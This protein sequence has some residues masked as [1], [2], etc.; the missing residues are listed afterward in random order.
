MLPFLYQGGVTMVTF[1]SYDGACALEGKIHESHVR[2][3]CQANAHQ[4]GKN[5]L[6]PENWQLHTPQAMAACVLFRC[7]TRL[8]EKTP[9]KF[10]RQEAPQ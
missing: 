7:M 3:P 10:C 5:G 6:A 2:Q 9:C 8:A 1:G 4:H